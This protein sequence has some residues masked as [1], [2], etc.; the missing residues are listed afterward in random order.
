MTSSHHSGLNRVM[1]KQQTISTQ[2][3]AA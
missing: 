1:V 2:Q 3:Y